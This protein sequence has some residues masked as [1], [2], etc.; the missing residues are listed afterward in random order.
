MAIEV[1]RFRKASTAARAILPS[2]VESREALVQAQ[3]RL[4]ACEDVLAIARALVVRGQSIPDGKGM[5]E[6]DKTRKIDEALM[7][8]PDYQQAHAE[9]RQAQTNAALEA[10]SVASY[11]DMLSVYRM[12]TKEREVTALLAVRS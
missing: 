7:A 2:I 9:Y 5:T 1:K 4:R 3:A 8:D 11:S 12:T 6:A 10:A